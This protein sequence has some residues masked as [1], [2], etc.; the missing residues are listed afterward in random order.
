[1]YDLTHR[2]AQDAATTTATRR[3]AAQLQRLGNLAILLSVIIAGCSLSIAVAGACWNALAR[4]LL[5]L[6]GMP[7]RSLRRVVLLEAALPLLG[8]AVV[9]AGGGLLT[10]E[11][12]YRRRPCHRHPPAGPCTT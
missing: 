9:S 11:L 1:M 5:R 4:S 10:A 8:L 3:D 7:L 2:I 12:P 6:A